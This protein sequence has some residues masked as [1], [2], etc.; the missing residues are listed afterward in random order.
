MSLP[1]DTACRRS[2]LASYA[3]WD[4][5]A[6]VPNIRSIPE[7]VKGRWGKSAVHAVRRRPGSVSAQDEPPVAR[8]TP[9]AAVLPYRLEVFL[10]AVGA[11]E[12]HRTLSAR[13]G[14]G[15]P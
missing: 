11:I 15:R 1:H 13:R 12:R 5:P 9:P 8:Q 7:G 2:G 14:H 10:A 6:G 3:G 4:A